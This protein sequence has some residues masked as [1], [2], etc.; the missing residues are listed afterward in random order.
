MNT[1]NHKIYSDKLSLHVVDLTQIETHLI[2]H[3]RLGLPCKINHSKGN[4]YDEG[5]QCD[6]RL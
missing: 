4:S 1:K 6:S 5:F 2:A 3:C